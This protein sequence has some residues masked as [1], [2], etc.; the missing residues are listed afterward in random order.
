MKLRVLILITLLT[1]TSVGAFAAACSTATLATYDTAGFSCTIGDKTFSNFTY[2]ASGSLGLT[3]TEIKLT[4]VSS[5]GEFGFDFTAAWSAFGT[6]TSDSLIRYN[7]AAGSGFLITDAQLSMLGFAASNI[8]QVSVAD[9]F[10]NGV[11]LSVFYNPLCASTSS[12]VTSTGTTFPGVA[13]LGVTKDIA[14]TTS[15]SGTASLS[16]VSNTV[17]QTPEPAS[18]LLL[19]TGLLGIGAIARR[20]W[21]S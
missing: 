17:S 4:P 6:N 7:I 19:G 16:F 12:C 15:G 3:D 5:G 11:N 20:K 13:T 10:T 21:L 18:L 1:L 2:T 9:N 14:L 8:A